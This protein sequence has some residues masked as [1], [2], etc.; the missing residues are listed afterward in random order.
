MSTPGAHPGWAEAMLIAHATGA[1]ATAD[2]L[3]AAEAGAGSIESLPLAQA[4]GRILAADLRATQP[5]PHVATA[6]MDGYAVAGDPPWLLED[7]QGEGRKIH[8]RSASTPLAPG[9]ARTIVTGG[10]VPAGASGVVRQEYTET[11]P[12]EPGSAVPNSA[13]HQLRIRLRPDAPASELEPGRHIRPAGREAKAGELLA[14][15]GDVLTPTRVAL[16]AIC[17][18]DEVPVHRPRTV[19]LLLTGDEVVTSG[20]PEAGQVRDAF[21]VQLPHSLA[22]RG[23]AIAAIRRIGDDRET[24]REALLQLAAQ[25]DMIVTTGGTARSDA[26]HVRASLEALESARVIIGQ[27]GMRPGHPTMLTVLTTADDRTV[28]VLSLPGNPLA[29]MAAARVVGSALI[30][31]LTRRPAE[32]PLTVPVAS[33]LPGETVDRLVPATVEDGSTAE[34]PAAEA[35]SDLA[36]TEATPSE[37]RWAPRPHVAAHM[38]RGL[39]GA[40]GWLVLPSHPVA[41]GERIPF[42]P[43][44]E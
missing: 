6:A 27:L 32:V 28:P 30:R 33:S 25:A 22:R 9:W 21:E 40:Q 20:V 5:V 19:A 14:A 36:G 12:A 31:G 34:A 26:D 10:Q 29:A 44:E 35:G 17:G 42:L 11:Q 13:D 16:A 15:A 24:T 43:L 18:F 38:M 23:L 37:A 2:S 4:H 7:Q 1:Q 41:A 39:A 3:A 8:V